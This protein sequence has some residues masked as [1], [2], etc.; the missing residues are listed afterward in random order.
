MWLDTESAQKLNNRILV[1]KEMKIVISRFWYKLEEL[2]ILRKESNKD[3]NN[4]K[5][6]YQLRARK[7][8]GFKMRKKVISLYFFS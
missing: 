5:Y 8:N 4:S 1:Q 6:S 3:A 7:K 2:H